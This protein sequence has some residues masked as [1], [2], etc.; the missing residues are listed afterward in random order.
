MSTPV[1]VFI[2]EKRQ[3]IKRFC[4]CGKSEIIARGL[5]KST[6]IFKKS[7]W[8]KTPGGSHISQV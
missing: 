6:L 5:A 3:G 4:T 7:L 1:L 2:M 8:A